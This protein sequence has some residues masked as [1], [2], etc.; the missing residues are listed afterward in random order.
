M[1]RKRIASPV[2]GP[3][4]TSTEMPRRTRSG[5]PRRILNLLG[6]IEAVEEHHAGRPRGFGILRR[7]E[8]AGKLFAFERHVDNFDL[9][10]RQR[11][12]LMEAFDGL[13][14]GVERTRIFRRAEAFAHLV[15]MAGAQIERGGRHAGCRSARNFSAWPR[16]VSATFTLAS[17][18]A[19]S[20]SALL[21]S[22]IRPMACSSLMSTPPNGAVPS[23][24]TNAADQ[25]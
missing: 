19:S 20:S 24:F 16:T 6:D 5:T 17:N 4:I 3:S 25:R 8:I 15:I 12:E 18:H 14:V 21:P 11:D 7:D 9:A 23:M 13:A 10:A 2:P 1:P 22:S